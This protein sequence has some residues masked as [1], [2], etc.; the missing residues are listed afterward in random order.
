MSNELQIIKSGNKG[1]YSFWYQGK[2]YGYFSTK[3]KC[4]KEA[5]KGKFK[6]TKFTIPTFIKLGDVSAGKIVLVSTVWV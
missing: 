5:L 4:E 2:G 1:L 3:D 6:N